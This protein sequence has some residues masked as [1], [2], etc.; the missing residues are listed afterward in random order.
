MDFLTKNTFKVVGKLVS[1]DLKVGQRKDGKGG[2]ISG[3]A[4]VVA[5]LDGRENEFEIS[6]F[7]NQS[8]KDGKESQLFTSYSKLGD[9]VGKKIEVSGDIRESRFW[10][11]NANQMVSSQKL[12]GR[13]VRGVAETTEDEA[14]F[15]LGGFVVEELV[16][17]KNKDND[18]YRYDLTLGQANYKGDNMSRFIVHVNPSAIEIKRGV[19]QYHVG[20]TVEVYGDLRFIVTK[21]TVEQKNE[22]GFGAPIVRTYVN[23]QHNFFITGGTAAITDAAK[24]MYPSDVIRSLVGAYKARDTELMND[25]KSSSSS[26]SAS[27][28]EEETKISFRQNSL[29]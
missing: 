24:G 17:K 13:F 11:S 20:Q 8:T 2:F 18:V 9:L 1:Q 16:E 6:F 21:S 26:S 5:N 25:A 14:S 10:S 22:G 15:E 27:P 12:S 7:T 4:V 28:V 19:E 23:K 29:I 3:N